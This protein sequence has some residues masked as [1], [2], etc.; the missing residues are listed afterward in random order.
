MDNIQWFFG[1][2]VVL[3]F[4]WLKY[5]K[6]EPVEDTLFNFRI[7]VR[8]DSRKIEDEEYFSIEEKLK[9]YG[10]AIIV[11]EELLGGSWKV[12]KDDKMR[13][14]KGFNEG[15]NSK[16]AVLFI[17]ENYRQI[18]LL[19]EFFKGKGKVFNNQGLHVHLCIGQEVIRI[20]ADEFGL[21]IH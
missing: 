11:A 4:I 9:M 3:A 8:C 21:F 7:D 10:P 6:P 1:A 2:L 18:K 12:I 17:E 16:R 19:E 5:K 14:I 13:L 15:K 20:G